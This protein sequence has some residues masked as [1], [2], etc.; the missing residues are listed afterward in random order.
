MSSISFASTCKLQSLV[1]VDLS[2]NEK[3]EEPLDILE[4]SAAFSITLIGDRQLP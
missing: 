2:L 3:S 1:C 4:C